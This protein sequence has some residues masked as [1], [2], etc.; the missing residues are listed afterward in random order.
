MLAAHPV[1]AETRM[2]EKYNVGGF[3]DVPGS[4]NDALEGHARPVPIDHATKE[5]LA[6]P[7][8]ARAIGAANRYMA[9][10][11]KTTGLM[12]I[13]DGK[14]LF[15]AYQGMGSA[16]SEFFS[17]SI[18]KSLTSLAVGKALCD[19]HLPGLDTK[20]GAIVPELNNSNYGKSTVKQ[21]LMMSSGAYEPKFAGQPRFKGGLGKRPKT[22]KPFRRGMFWPIRLGQITISDVLWG[23]AWEKAEDKNDRPPGAVF[24]Y[25]SGDTLALGVVVE[26][27]TGMSLARYFDRTIWR[28]VRSAGG[29]HW[30]A[31]RSGT[32][33]AA[34]GFQTR[35]ADWGRLAV[36]ISTEIKK[37][38]CY[39]DYLRAATS[40]QIA[41]G[42]RVG[43]N[44]IKFRGY[45]YQWWTNNQRAPGFWGVGYAGQ[46]LA[47][48]PPSGKILIK[49][50][51]ASSSRADRALFQLFGDW[52]T[53]G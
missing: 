41:T 29:A 1:L 38:G 14:I 10:F 2:L 22:G 50:S 18:G 32:T 44:K 3:I 17:M 39:G 23:P 49:F 36:W 8:N 16:K 43:R 30:E 48:S 53:S 42:G 52:H 21:L 26:R 4:A 28:S 13:A 19:G 5:V 46:H 37:S 9:D 40:K 20:A 47:I 11:P 6:R 27:A 51:Y 45:G 31:D 12:L 15:E 24:R 7:A 25:K 34:S 35:M 33:V